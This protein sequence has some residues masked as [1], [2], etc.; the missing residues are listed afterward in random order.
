MVFGEDGQAPSSLFLRVQETRIESGEVLSFDIS[1][2]REDTQWNINLPD[3]GSSYLVDL[4]W[5]DCKG[6]EMS[7]AQSKRVETYPAYWQKH[8]EELVG[9][10]SSF[11]ANFS[12]LVTKEGEIVDNPVIRDLAQTLSKGVL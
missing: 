10:Y 7:L 3:M 8:S 2:E 11:L 9:D 4:C 5:R 12:S 6:N 1:I